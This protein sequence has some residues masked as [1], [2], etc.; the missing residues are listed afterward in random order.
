MLPLYKIVGRWST[1]L[2][3]YV[4]PAGDAR[5]GFRA[6]VELDPRFIRP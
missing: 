2:G 1:L 4:L 5:T 3:D 6:P